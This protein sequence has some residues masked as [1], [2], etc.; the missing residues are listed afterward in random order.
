MF[1]LYAK[2]KGNY[3]FDISIPCLKC[4]AAILYLSDYVRVPGRHM[5]RK[6]D[7]ETYNESVTKT[8][9][10]NTFEEIKQNIF[11]ANN[12]NL[13]PIINLQNQTTA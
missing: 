4:F 5:I 9:R 3:P 2:D 8:M 1:V 12:Q 7:T 13:I 10:R 11:C 6:V